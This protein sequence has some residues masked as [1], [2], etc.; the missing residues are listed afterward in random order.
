VGGEKGGKNQQ[1]CGVKNV[2]RE[3]LFSNSNEKKRKIWVENPSSK[4]QALTQ[5]LP[6]RNGHIQESES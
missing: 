2:P 6:L 4:K 3:A 1:G 5:L